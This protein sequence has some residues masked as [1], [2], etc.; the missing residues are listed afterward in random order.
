MKCAFFEKTFVTALVLAAAGYASHALAHTA[1]GTL[2]P[3]GNNPND[4]ALAQVTCYDDG[5]GPPDHLYVQV[6]DMSPPVPG[7]LVSAQAFKDSPTPTMGNT[8]DPV[9]GDANASA[10]ITNVGTGNGLYWLSVSKTHVAGPR[11]F[12][13]TYH[14]QTASDVHTGTCGPG[15]GCG[16]IQGTWSGN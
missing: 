11:N 12:T 10:A 16:I 14:C 7:L 5:D 1:I 13:V 15:D 6:Q 9:S 4:T 8:T 3:A 2:D